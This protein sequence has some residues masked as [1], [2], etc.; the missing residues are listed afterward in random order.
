MRWR[1]GESSLDRQPR[2]ALKLDLSREKKWHMVSLL[3]VCS[4]R[5][6]AVG[7]EEEAFRG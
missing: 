7:Y 5:P 6:R 1:P 2:R 4:P 3:C